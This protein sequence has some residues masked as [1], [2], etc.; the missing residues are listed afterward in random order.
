MQSE[1]FL[2]GF[3]LFQLFRFW[4]LFS[5]ILPLN[6]MKP[7][8][9]L[10]QWRPKS[11]TGY[12]ALLFLY[13]FHDCWLPPQIIPLNIPFELAL[14]FTMSQWDPW[15]LSTQ[16]NFD[17]HT[18]FHKGKRQK[19]KNRF[20]SQHNRRLTGTY[21]P[22]CLF[23]SSVKSWWGTLDKTASMLN[24]IMRLLIPTLLGYNCSDL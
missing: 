1:K 20:T 8:N 19:W 23:A 11:N 3:L 24:W 6:P 12:N 16:N 13:N 7:I 9:Y 2:P 21:K 14:S 17:V 5:P 4:I 18:F 10:F 22:A 15:H